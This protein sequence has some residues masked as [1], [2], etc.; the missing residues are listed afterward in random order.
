MLANV[1][2]NLYA[3]LRDLTYSGV[4]T[5][6][7]WEERTWEEISRLSQTSRCFASASWLLIPLKLLLK[8]FIID[9]ISE[10]SESD[11]TVQ[12]GVGSVPLSNF[13][14]NISHISRSGWEISLKPSEPVLAYRDPSFFQTCFRLYCLVN[15]LGQFL[16]CWLTSFLFNFLKSCLT[17]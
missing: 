13:C 10:L 7:Q 2:G 12:I 6:I 14:M 1:W 11:L 15:C 4:D 5:A 16:Y 17:F 9:K 8:L 3:S